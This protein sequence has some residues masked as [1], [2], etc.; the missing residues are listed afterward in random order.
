MLFLIFLS[1]KAYIQ[2][3]KMLRK[4]EKS[5][6]DKLNFIF[7]DFLELELAIFRKLQHY[8]LSNKVL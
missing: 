8:E 2:I 3:K 7:F 6:P 4:S 1:A 5:R